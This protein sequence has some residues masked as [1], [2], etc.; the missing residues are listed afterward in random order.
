[1]AMRDK[2]QRVRRVR[3]L[4]RLVTIAVAGM[5]LLA[6]CASSASHDAGAARAGAVT[7]AA[8]TGTPPAGSRAEALA[9][10][11]R[12]LTRLVAPPG[13]RPANPVPGPLSVS[14]AGGVSSY[15]VDVHRFLLVREPMAD[16]HSFLLAHVPAGMQWAG[17]GLAPGTTNTVSVLW[18]GYRPQSLPAGIDMAQLGT[19]AMPSAGGVLIRVDAGVTWFPGR[20]AAERLSAASFRSVTVAATTGYPRQ[21]TVARGF[22]SRAVI[23]RLV[24]LV[25]ALPVQPRLLDLRGTLPA[26]VRQLLSPELRA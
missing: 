25:N 8:R 17:A 10:A 20:S 3:A 19:A 14:S 1:M 2:H 6:G 13:A 22:T 26:A 7:T 4:G 24:A 21:R 18:V 5:A 16:V 12:L 11:S 23:D 15:S 9:L